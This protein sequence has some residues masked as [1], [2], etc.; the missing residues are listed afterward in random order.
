M[1]FDQLG[2]LFIADNG[3]FRIRK[4]TIAPVNDNDQDGVDNAI[5]NCPSNTN[6]TQID[7]D[8]DGQGNACDID[9]DNDGLPDSIEVASGLDPL[10]PDTDGDGRSD[11]DEVAAG[12][13]PLF[14]PANIVPIITIILTDE[15]P[16]S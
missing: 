4:V 13:N 8:N 9:D 15:T 6:L 5:D 11:G 3:N 14:N 16:S 1:T 2:N 10:N 7:T 12:T